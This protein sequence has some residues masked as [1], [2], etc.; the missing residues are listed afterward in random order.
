MQKLIAVAIL[1]ATIFHVRANETNATPKCI[2]LALAPITLRENIVVRVSEP[3]QTKVEKSPPLDRVDDYD[4]S[5]G[6]DGGTRRK[7]LPELNKAESA[8]KTG[9]AKDLFFGQLKLRLGSPKFGIEDWTKL[10][11]DMQPLNKY[12]DSQMVWGKAMLSRSRGIS[13]NLSES[14][15]ILIGVREKNRGPEGFVEVDF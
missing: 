9:L 13:F 7:V 8:E 5:F 14:P 3:T 15:I 10:G 12:Y 6:R 11:T 4:F 1:I 2:E